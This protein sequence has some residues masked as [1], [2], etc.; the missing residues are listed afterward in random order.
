LQ[1]VLNTAEATRP[2]FTTG[3]YGFGFQIGR[4]DEARSHGHGGGAPKAR[5]ESA[6]RH[7][8]QGLRSRC[9]TRNIE[10]NTERSARI[11]RKSVPALLENTLL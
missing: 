9:T 4:P 10:A 3:A 1:R 2:Q 5:P 8:C 6:G 7:L 11:N